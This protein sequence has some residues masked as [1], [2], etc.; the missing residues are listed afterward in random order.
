MGSQLLVCLI[1]TVRP[2]V[3]TRVQKA[4]VS[5]MKVLFKILFECFEE[6]HR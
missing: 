2:F 3:S 1:A 5:Q 4:A 6:Q